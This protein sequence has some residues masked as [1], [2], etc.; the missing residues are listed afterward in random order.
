MTESGLPYVVIFIPAY[1]EE[2]SIR[3]LINKINESYVSSVDARGYASE[4]LVVDDGSRDDTARIAREA[5]VKTVISHDRNR[6]LGA[7]TRTAMQHACEMGADIAVKIDADYQYEPAD[8]DKVV[9][10]IMDDVADC[11]FGTRLTGGLQYEMPLS[12]AIGNRFFSWLVSRLTGLR[13]TDAQTGL[14]ALGRRYLEQYT[15][16]DDY[17]VT[18]QLILD[19]FGKHMRVI[20]V[21]VLFYRRTSGTSFITWRYPFKVIPTILRHYICIIRNR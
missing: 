4:I 21:S 11:V 14:F 10:P 17:N 8:I 7:A 6:G 1:N 3:A 19:A 2:G 15:I 20:E 5:G 12:R 13:I 16:L 9:R 18:Q